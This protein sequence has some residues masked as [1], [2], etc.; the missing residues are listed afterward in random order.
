MYE[1]AFQRMK[2]AAGAFEIEEIVQRYDMWK[3]SCI[4]Y[5]HLLLYFL[6]D[7]FKVLLSFWIVHLN[8]RKFTN[9]QCHVL[10]PWK[11][12]VYFCIVYPSKL[13]NQFIMLSPSFASAWPMTTL[14][15]LCKTTH[16][17][18]HG[19]VKGISEFIFWTSMPVTPIL[20]ASK[21]LIRAIPLMLAAA[22]P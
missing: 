22:I 10:Y 5:M 1:E 8:S 18:A 20:A 16:T 7:N 12:F 3:S 21:Y 6:C 2:R 19:R 17:F 13:V 11:V 14:R 4:N 9:F 15:P